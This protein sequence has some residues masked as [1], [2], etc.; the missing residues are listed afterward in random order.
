MNRLITEVQMKGWIAHIQQVKLLHRCKFTGN[1]LKE[2]QQ[3]TKA[4]KKCVVEDKKIKSEFK[5][6][7]F[8]AEDHW[9]QQIK[10]LGTPE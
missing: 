2:L 9:K 1:E 10:F 5:F 4:W 3:L 6:P 8:E 7:N